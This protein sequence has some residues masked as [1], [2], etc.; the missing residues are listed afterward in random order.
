MTKILL[1]LLF[2]AAAGIALVRFASQPPLRGMSRI[3]GHSQTFLL[4]R[5]RPSVAFALGP[6]MRLGA[7]GWCTV[8]PPSRESLEGSA[9]IWLALYSHPKGLL[10]TAVADGEEDW[11]WDPGNQ[12]AFPAIRHMSQPE[13]RFTL[14]E[15]ISVLDRAHDPFCAAANPLGSE[16]PEKGACLV[17]RARLLQE[18]DRCQIILEYHEDLP[19]DLMGEAAFHEDILNAFQTRARLAGRIIRLDKTQA[20]AMTED[21][22]KMDT[23][24]KRVSRRLLAA[25]TGKMHRRGRL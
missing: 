18:V 19:D 15:T 22:E 24:D 6:E 5:A 2:V 16:H 17:Y 1:I 23:L 4:A 7:C 10:A 20:T 11:E 9:K 25:W 21:M 3:P 14:F 13:G 12:D 8:R